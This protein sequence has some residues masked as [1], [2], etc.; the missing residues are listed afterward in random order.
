MGRGISRRG[1]GGARRRQQECSPIDQSF[2]VLPSRYQACGRAARVFCVCFVLWFLIWALSRFRMPSLN[3]TEWL[4]HQSLTRGVVLELFRYQRHPQGRN[5]SFTALDL[6]HRGVW[7]VSET[8]AFT[9]KEILV[10]EQPFDGQEFGD[11][12]T[13]DF[14]SSRKR[15]GCNSDHGSMAY[16]QGASSS[17]CAALGHLPL[18]GR[19]RA[20]EHDTWAPYQCFSYGSILVAVLIFTTLAHYLLTE[21]VYL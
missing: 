3:S 17:L 7:E 15:K 20:S 11:N 21:N 19:E 9:R 5:R 12:L 16:A 10:E 18:F 13:C 6:V 4:P 2:H 1:S 8:S 14:D